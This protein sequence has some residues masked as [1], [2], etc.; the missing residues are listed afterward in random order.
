MSV[1]RNPFNPNDPDRFAIWEMLVERDIQAFVRQDWSM[2]EDDFV[3]EGFMGIDGRGLSNPDSWRLNFPTLNSYKE[4]WLDQAEEFSSNEYA[5]DPQTGL[6]EATTLRDIEIADKSALARKKFDGALIKKSGESVRLNWQTMYRCKK[7][8]DVWK[9]AG[10]LG[11]LPHS[12]GTRENILPAKKQPEHASQHDT[13]GPYSPV[14]QV[15]PG[16]I[17]VISGQAAINQVGEVV[18]DTIE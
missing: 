16:E 12:F 1:Y 14:L 8:K 6:L 18:G 4:Y 15:H 10:F 11:F 7:I 3:E 13:A 17:I 2:V 5:S 9:I